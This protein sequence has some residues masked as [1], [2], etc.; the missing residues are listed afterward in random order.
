VRVWI[1]KG[2]KGAKDAKGWCWEGERSR[3]AHD[4]GE[5]KGMTARVA[6]LRGSYR[7]AEERIREALRL[8][9]Y[10]PE[11][12]RILLKPNVVTVP[13]WLPLGGT[14]RA[15]VTDVRFLEALLRVFAG[16][17]VTIA[18]GAAAFCD[19]DEVLERTGITALARR[20][21]AR[22]VNL[23]K[24]ERFEV[25][26]AYGTLRLPTLLRTHE[27]INVPKLKTHFQT[28]VTLARKNQK[29]LLAS[30]DKVRF[31]RE[32][33]LHEAIRA[34]AE[35]V[36]PALSIVDGIVG[37]EG[38]GPGLGHPRRVG[39]IVVGRD[40]AAVDVACCDLISVEL[41]R[42]AH[43]DRVAYRT[44]GRTIE[45]MKVCFD[46]PTTIRVANVIIHAPPSGCS[47]CLLSLQE[48]AAALWRSPTH[49]LRGSWSCILHRTD[50]VYGAA[51]EIPAAARGRVVCYGDCTRAL[52]ERE[53]LRFV[54]G[55]PP[56]VEAHLRLY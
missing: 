32:L 35:V 11:R 42:V 1:T 36:Q 21:G 7:T 15:A 23:D 6:I 46:A 24:A 18:E 47:R 25:D 45:K 33:D 27:Y 29:G 54:P 30:A 4:G 22:V 13:R 2:T 37:L 48:G 31:H 3:G 39:V 8:L 41:E 53:G 38:P 51:E 56:G 26:W 49:V 44:V 17:E 12:R 16:Y 28:G 34:L 9:D 40:M 50:V 20:Y 14:P 19:T 55:C 52:A 10:R 43:L 5:E